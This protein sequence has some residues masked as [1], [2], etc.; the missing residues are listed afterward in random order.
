MSTL[1]VVVDWPDRPGPGPSAPET[2]AGRMVDCLRDRAPD[3]TAVVAAKG[4][5]LAIGKLVVAHK[6][7]HAAQPLVDRE[8]GLYLVADVRIDNR[9]DLKTE[10]GVG[11]ESTDAEIVLAGYRKWG[12]HV[13]EHLIG[14]FA[15]VV[16]D[17][18]ERTLFAA[19]DPFG[20]R[21]LVYRRSPGRLL[22]ASDVEQILEVDETA[23]VVDDRTVV[24]YLVGKLRSVERTFFEGIAAV[25]PGNYLLARQGR[26]DV[27]RWWRPPSGLRQI[28]DHE[29][30]YSEFRRLFALAVADRLDSDH[31]ICMHVSGGF[32]SSA[33]ALTAARVGARVPLRGISAF[34][35]GLDCNEKPLV[36]TLASRL[37][38]PVEY[39]RGTDV[40]LNDLHDPALS[41]PWRRAAFGDGSLGGLD[42]VAR[43]Q[44]RVV[45]SGTGGDIWQPN[46]QS[47]QDYFLEGRW[48][49]LVQAAFLRPHLEWSKR[50][51]VLRRAV[52]FFMPEALAHALT[53]WRR[54]GGATPYLTDHA[55]GLLDM[56]ARWDDCSENLQSAAAREQLRSLLRPVPV[57][58][59]E[60]QQVCAAR[61][62]VEMRF[63]FLDTRLL[64]LLWSLPSTIW[65]PPAYVARFHR[66]ALDGQFPPEFK[67]RRRK[68]LF[69]SAVA[70]RNAKARP[71]IDT[72]LENLPW[73]CAAYIDGP[74]ARQAVVADGDLA[75][76][77]ATLEAWLKMVYVRDAER[78]SEGERK[79]GS[80]G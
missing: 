14:D 65:T 11:R 58:V 45:L 51:R 3:G 8:A 29:E 47:I 50:L 19:R 66:H 79:H 55:R 7:G 15:F 78:G 77:V 34:Y 28:D 41:G 46:M 62:A 60:I 75:W 36:D 25:P 22:V 61:V 16:W 31:P 40:V 72:T 4:A 57:Y 48:K 56:P 23:W 70:Q 26:L 39:W 24:D 52:G 67:A 27:G 54:E 17:E 30:C 53:F 76:G 6:Q 71:V 43:E 74:A 49:Q 44:A 59:V 20:V 5:A 35:P 12:A 18:R 38:F 73:K 2:T 21:P 63:P 37:P 69:A 42:I 68:N 32:D 64:T 80:Y 1:A 13:P 10:L 33:I 9:E